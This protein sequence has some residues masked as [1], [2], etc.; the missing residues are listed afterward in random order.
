MNDQELAE[1]AIEV[2]RDAV[3]DVPREPRFVITDTVREWN[4]RLLVEVSDH[5]LHVLARG[6]D[7]V[8]FFNEQ[9]EEIGWRD[10]GRTGTAM[11]GWLDR[12][13]VRQFVVQEL[14]LP[15]TSRLGTLKVSELPPLGWT[16]EGVL[17][18]ADVPT[19]ADVLRFWFDTDHKRVIQ[20]IRGPWPPVP[21]GATP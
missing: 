20:C 18:T 9:G 21:Q 1:R 3:G 17:F 10:D 11:P 4:E 5:V 13:T 16:L 8:V 2:V 6:P 15:P 12:E 19:P 7:I 14:E